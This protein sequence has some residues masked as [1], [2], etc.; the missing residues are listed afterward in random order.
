M[1][2]IPPQSLVKARKRRPVARLDRVDARAKLPADRDPY[3]HRLA[4]GRH[5]GFR[6]MA[7]GSSGTWLARSYDG[8]RY[9]YQPLG[10]FGALA[11]KER[12]DAA[13]LAA[14][15]WFRHLEMGGTT[16][17]ATVKLACER[18]VDAVRIGQSGKSKRRSPEAWDGAADDLKGRYGRI[19]YHDPIARIELAKLTERHVEEWRQ[20]VTARVNK[21][22]R[23]LSLGSFNRDAT[24]LRAALNHAHRK[25]LI[26]SDH[27]WL[28]ALEPYENAD[29][30]R[31]LYLA[32]EKRAKL[33]QNSSVEA[34]RF[35]RTLLLLPLRPGDVAKL[36]VE[37]FD[38][39]HGTL[40]VP[41]GK[42]QSRDIPLSSD[43]TAHFKA[44]AKGKL[45]AAWLISRDSGD[46]WTK[47]AWRDEIKSAAKAAKLPRATVAYTLRHSTVTDLVTAGTDLF[48]VAKLAGTSI[49][50]I[51]RHYGHLQQTHARKALEGLSLK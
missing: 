15:E 45:P 23:K 27:A 22:G 6:R 40:A 24:A 5:L 1:K 34:K 38:A 44:C 13:R 28:T 33:L 17:R 3:W 47:E 26:T 46:Q 14:E 18:Y 37:H 9:Q 41:T 16:E 48:T 42:T 2:P 36:K 21:K 25:H 43:A 11:D 8:T 30:R 7:A 29:R 39:R 50:M 12:F 49:A 32:R 19:V 10:D 4:E 20:R 51:E 35:V 31:D